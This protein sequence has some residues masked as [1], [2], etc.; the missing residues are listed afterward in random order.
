MNCE[1]CGKK[2]TKRQVR[3][4]QKFCSCK[5]FGASVKKDY[6][7]YDKQ[8]LICGKKIDGRK[9]KL[10]G[11]NKVCSRKCLGAYLNGRK[12]NKDI[13]SISLMAKM[14]KPVKLTEYK[15]AP[16]WCDRYND[17]DIK[18][19]MCYENGVKVC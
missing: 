15:N 11:T 9:V 19:V 1:Q 13:K 8:C 4:G 12:Y 2:L 17:N 5:C 10:K 14:K 6:S 3:Q 16:K 7:M 18:C